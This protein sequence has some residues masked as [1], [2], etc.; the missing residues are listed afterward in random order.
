MKAVFT[1]LLHASQGAWEELG[2]PYSLK[3]F[4]S[5]P[6]AQETCGNGCHQWCLDRGQNVGSFIPCMNLREERVK[7]SSLYPGFSWEDEQSTFLVVCTKGI[8]CV[9]L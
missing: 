1:A 7:S 4:Q 9:S 6:Q 8:D 3:E 2:M 5:L